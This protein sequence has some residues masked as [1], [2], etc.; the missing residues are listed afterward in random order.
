[1]LTILLVGV[2]GA[3][4]SVCRFLVSTWIQRS[5]HSSFPWGTYVVNGTGSLLIGGVY[6]LLDTGGSGDELLVF[7][8]AGLLGGYTTFSTFSL[9]NLKLLENRRYGWLLHNTFGQVAGGLLFAAVGYWLGS[10]A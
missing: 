7:L 8:V 5:S 4:G 2:G 6:G 1:M 3:I 9:E 10:V